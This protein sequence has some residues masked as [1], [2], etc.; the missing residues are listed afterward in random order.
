MR[1]RSFEAVRGVLLCLSAFA[2][3]LGGRDILLS[4][5][6]TAALSGLV[7]ACAGVLVLTLLHLQP[8][9]RR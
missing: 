9:L 6:T 1:S 8:L 5:G 3:V 4:W 2:F 7:T